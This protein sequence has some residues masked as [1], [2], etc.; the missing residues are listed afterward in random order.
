[1]TAKITRTFLTNHTVDAAE[2]APLITD[3]YQSLAT[4]QNPAPVVVAPEV[5]QKRKYTRRAQGVSVDTQEA[6]S[7][8]DD[9]TSNL[10]SGDDKWD[11]HGQLR[12]QTRPEPMFD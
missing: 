6:Q 8:P 5:R 4:A 1:M 3:V 7:A 9:Q 11:E 12:Q 2:I 10:A